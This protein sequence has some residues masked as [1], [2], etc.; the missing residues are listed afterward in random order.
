MCHKEV[1][2]SQQL[3]EFSEG[4]GAN[5][6][7]CATEAEGENGREGKQKGENGEALAS[8]NLIRPIAAVRNDDF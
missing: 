8:S 5:G 7:D 3:A 2:T 6:P 4:I 1:N